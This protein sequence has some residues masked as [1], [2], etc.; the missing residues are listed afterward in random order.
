MFDFC[1]HFANPQS[2]V[3]M[4]IDWDQPLKGILLQ[5]MAA[6][7]NDYTTVTRHCQNQ[8]R[9]TVPSI[10]NIMCANDLLFRLVLFMS[11]SD[12][13]IPKNVALCNK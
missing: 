6:K 13:L 8:V 10:R 11:F 3:M 7:S 12:C 2:L 4:L 5:S 1:V 9:C